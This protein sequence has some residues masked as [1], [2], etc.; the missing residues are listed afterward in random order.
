[1][2][3][4]DLSFLKIGSQVVYVGCGC[5]LVA[6]DNCGRFILLPVPSGAGFTAPVCPCVLY[7]SGWKV[8]HTL[9]LLEIRPGTGAV[10]AAELILGTL[11]KLNQ[12]GN[13]RWSHFVTTYFS[14]HHT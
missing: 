1:M 10:A 3:S 8:L 9:L 2:N 4:I 14:C 11:N 13:S 5:S 6:K 12:N 7:C